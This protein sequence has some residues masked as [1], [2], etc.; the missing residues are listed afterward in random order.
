MHNKAAMFC[1][2]LNRNSAHKST[3]M[4]LILC[5]AVCL[6]GFVYQSCKKENCIGCRACMYTNKCTNN[7]TFGDVYTCTL[8]WTDTVHTHTNIPVALASLLAQTD[9]AHQQHPEKQTQKHCQTDLRYDLCV[10]GHPFPYNWVYTWVCTLIQTF[11]PSYVI[12]EICIYSTHFCFV[13]K[14]RLVFPWLGNNTGSSI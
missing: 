7:C 13:K 10:C 9:Q 11:T 14:F 8:V 3:K 4:V 5:G 6:V 12:Y 2:W 1:I